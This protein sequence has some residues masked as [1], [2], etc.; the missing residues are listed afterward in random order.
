MSR[1]VNQKEV[2]FLLH[3][4]INTD[5]FEKEGMLNANGQSGEWP[6]LPR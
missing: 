1:Y 3:L 4:P 2:L 5:R 6:L